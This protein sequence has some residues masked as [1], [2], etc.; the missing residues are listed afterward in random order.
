VFTFNKNEDGFFCTLNFVGFFC[1]IFEAFFGFT[2]DL[3]PMDVIIFKG[4]IFVRRCK[5]HRDNPN[6]SPKN[7]K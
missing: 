2:L 6:E 5:I 7:L 4:K 1:W 3:S